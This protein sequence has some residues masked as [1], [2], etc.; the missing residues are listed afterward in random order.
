MNPTFEVKCWEAMYMFDLFIEI[1]NYFVNIIMK[2]KSYVIVNQYAIQ[3]F[4]SI[5]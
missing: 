2:N 5:F 1:I 3:V 4:P